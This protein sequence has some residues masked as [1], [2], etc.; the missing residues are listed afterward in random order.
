MDP[1]LREVLGC[2]LLREIHGLVDWKNEPKE[3]QELCMSAAEKVVEMYKDWIYHQTPKVISWPGM[4][5]NEGS[6]D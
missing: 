3:V 1:Q 6:N 5:R 4:E 2:I